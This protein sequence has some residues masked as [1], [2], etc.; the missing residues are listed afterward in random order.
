M[1]FPKTVTFRLIN[2]KTKSPIPN[3][4]ASLVLYAHSKNDYYVGPKISDKAGRVIF[5]K[6]DCL[7]EIEASQKM[8]LMDYSSS[9]DQ[10]LPKVSIKIKSR[11]EMVAAIENMR[12]NRKFFGEYW[13]CSEEYLKALSLTD[14]IK[15]L[16][17]LYEFTEADLLRQEVIVE[18]AENE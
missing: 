14:N 8:F 1:N 17:R 2:A 13:D 6:E 4:A 7:K 18:M 12:S 15:Y 10:C 11:D 16:P 3:V 9:L 5:T